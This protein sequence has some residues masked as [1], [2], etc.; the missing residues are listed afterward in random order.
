[1]FRAG[2]HSMADFLD[3]DGGLMA[4]DSTIFAFKGE[5]E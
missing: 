4:G 3:N 1:M 2:R 5:L